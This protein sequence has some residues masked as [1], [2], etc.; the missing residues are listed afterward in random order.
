VLF[1]RN[2]EHGTLNIFN[3]ENVTV[4]SCM[5]TDNNDTAYFNTK[6]FQG[7]GGG[8]SISYNVELAQLNSANVIVSNCKFNNNR[9]DPPD[10]LFASTNNLM[11]K[12][13]F[14]GR[15]GGLSMPIS[16][17]FPLNVV[18][19]NSVFENNFAKNYGG[20]LFYYLGGT[21]GN[22]TYMIANNTFRRNKALIGS[23]AMNFGNFANA[24][25]YTTLHATIYNCTFKE[26]KANHGGC[27]HAA[28]PS[29]FGIGV[30][31]IK[32]QNCTFSNN[33][34]FQY[35]GAIDATTISAFQSRQHNEPMEFI[36]W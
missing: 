22:Q 33:T 14:S 8:M 36:N 29:H 12:S 26:N 4:K 10:Y 21:N 3:C 25:P 5:F 17:T 32:F 9:A 31:F 27:L 34:S 13:I 1:Y 18:V 7:H 11:E 23:G 19:N 20:G 30:N 16:A 28:Y 35:G 15:G 6:P 24:A 2:H